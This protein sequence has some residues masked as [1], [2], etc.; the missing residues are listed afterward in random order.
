MVPKEITTLPNYPCKIKFTVV[1]D[2]GYKFKCVTNGSYSKNLRSVGDLQILGRWLKGRMEN[3]K[4]LKIGEK[5]T[6]D[7]FVRYKRNTIKLTK[8]TIPDTWYMDFGVEK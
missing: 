1:T 3:K 8:T 6:A 7:T 2:D 5:V 4:V